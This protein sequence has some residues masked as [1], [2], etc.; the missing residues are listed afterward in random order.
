[1][2]ST[3]PILWDLVGYRV[4][5]ELDGHLGRVFAARFVEMGNTVLT[6][7][8]DATVQWWDGHTGQR[9][10][11][12]RGGTSFLADAT[13]DTSGAMLVAT[14]GDGIIRFWDVASGRPLWTLQAHK[15]HAIGLHF[16]DGDLVTRGFTGEVT[17]WGLPP[18]ADIVKA[19]P[20]IVQGP[21]PI[22]H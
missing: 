21:G 8:A 20:L 6:S 7:G 1:M 5:A 10:R 2:L 3:S 4:I 11:V 12:F 9:R 16:E 17:R 19:L 22:H 18:S 15:S 14:G 13:L